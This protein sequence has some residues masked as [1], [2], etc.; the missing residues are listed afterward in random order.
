MKSTETT[1]KLFKVFI[2]WLERRYTRKLEKF[3]LRHSHD[4]YTTTPLLRCER[5]NARN[6]HLKGERWLLWLATGFIN[7]IA[8]HRVRVA[9]PFKPHSVDHKE[10]YH[11]R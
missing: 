11:E 9:M 10:I 4:F 7:D 6:P 3:W 1:M 8:M 2:R 5:S